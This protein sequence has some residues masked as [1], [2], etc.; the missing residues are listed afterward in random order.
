MAIGGVAGL[1]IDVERLVVAAPQGDGRVVAEQV[2]GL[3][4]LAHRLLADAAGVA[5]LQGQV[6]P[7]QQPVAVGG[8]VEL[9]PA[10]VGVDPQQ[11]EAG[12]AGERDVTFEVV[13]RASA[14]AMPGRPWLAAL[15]EEALAVDRR[16][17][18]SASAPG[19]ARSHGRSR[20]EHAGLLAGL[21]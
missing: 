2:D 5:P 6:L 8:V 7:E 10:D 19:A 4:G 3:A 12:V 15:E 1:G 16:R 20:S 9:G 18:S 14:S 21:R 11:V 13:G 17:S